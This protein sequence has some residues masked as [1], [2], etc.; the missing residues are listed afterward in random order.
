MTNSRRRSLEVDGL[1]SEL[2][3]VSPYT[4]H[5]PCKNPG[6]HAKTL[7]PD[8]ELRELPTHDLL[9]RVQP[10]AHT[11]PRIEVFHGCKVAIVSQASIY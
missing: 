5:D 8:K 9:E 2:H 11:V 1:G 3:M 4:I 7:M 6:I 10:I